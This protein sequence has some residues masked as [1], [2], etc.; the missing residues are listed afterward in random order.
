MSGNGVNHLD[1][2]PAYAGTLLGLANT[3]SATSGFLGPEV[4]GALTYRESSRAQW[5][6]VFYISAAIYSFGAAIFVVFGSGELQDWAVVPQTAAD[7]KH[8]EGHNI[9][10]KNEGHA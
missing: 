10:E 8:N 9:G 7:G 3:L 6:K 2:A 1:L 5:Q 4:V